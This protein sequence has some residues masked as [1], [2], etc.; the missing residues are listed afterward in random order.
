MNSYLWSQAEDAVSKDVFVI[1]G[2]ISLDEQTS[3]QRKVIDKFFACHDWGLYHE[4][5]ILALRNQKKILDHTFVS[6]HPG[7][8][9]YIS[10]NYVDKD[11]VGR[12]IAFQFF[13]ATDD[14]DIAF[15][16]LERLSA[17][18]KRNCNKEEHNSLREAI[19][20]PEVKKD[21][22]RSARRDE[23]QSDHTLIKAITVIGALL[24][25][26]LLIRSCGSH[27]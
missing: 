23:K 4:Q 12:L 3:E 26:L 18:I 17:L 2:N 9:V 6:Y 22:N 21:N 15:A 19:K 8:G 5:S 11:V 1:N 10:S 24:G 7:D 16:E 14:F 13:C 20:N 27:S 25:M